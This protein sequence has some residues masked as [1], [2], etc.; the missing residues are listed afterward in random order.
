MG[1]MTSNSFVRQY[2]KERSA[3]HDF[4]LHLTRDHEQAQDLIQETLYK[5][6]KYKT[7]YEKG[8]NWKAWLMTIMRNT[9]IN[10]YRKHK[11]RGELAHHAEQAAW[12][13]YKDA[14][15]FNNGESNLSVE[16]ILSEVEQLDDW[17]KTPFL[18]HY[19]GFKYEEIAETLELPLGTIKSRIY[20]ARQRL[21]KR[22]KQ[23]Y[24][25]PIT[26]SKGIW[27]ASH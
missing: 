15:Q 14:D 20:F 25:E 26:R 4:A 12:V 6:F 10:D 9:F 21:R 1:M 24:P 27:S 18:M 16:E 5:A 2:E 17:M 13:N 7:S 3:L 22:M 23:L 11:R 8:T 19:N